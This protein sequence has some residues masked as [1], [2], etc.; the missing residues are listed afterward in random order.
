M[1]IL[2]DDQNKQ[3]ETEIFNDCM[4]RLAENDPDAG[5]DLARFFLGELPNYDPEKSLAVVEGLMLQSAQLGSVHAKEYLEEMWP[6]MRSIM[7]RRLK[8]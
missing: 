5:F 8:R 1:T 2:N 7:I 6:D 3:I 4:K